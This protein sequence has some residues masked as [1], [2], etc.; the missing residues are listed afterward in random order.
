MVGDGER[1][2]GSASGDTA[3]FDGDGAV[4]ERVVGGDAI[5]AGAGNFQAERRGWKFFHRVARHHVE[6]DDVFACVDLER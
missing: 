4:F 2:F 5:T 3:D 1:D 6:G